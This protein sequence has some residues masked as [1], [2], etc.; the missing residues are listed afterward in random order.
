MAIVWVDDD[1]EVI[2][3]VIQPII[4]GGYEIIRFRTINEAMTSLDDL[5]TADLILLDMIIPPGDDQNDVGIY[6]GV[7]I[8]KKLRKEF[9]I[10]TP[11]IVFSVVN[12]EKL[13]DELSGLDVA[14]Y[15]RKPALPSELHKAVNE[16]LGK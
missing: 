16:V 1:I 5:R 9:D 8:L 7:W 10:N 6:S 2:D 14:K 12:P 11:V 15:V 4:D 3:P 13:K